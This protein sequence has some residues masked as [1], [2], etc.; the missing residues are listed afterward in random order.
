MNYQ[1]SLRHPLKCHPMY[2]IKNTWLQ[3]RHVY[4]YA[5]KRVFIYTLTHHFQPSIRKR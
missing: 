4:I 1:I 3:A 2:V 5:D